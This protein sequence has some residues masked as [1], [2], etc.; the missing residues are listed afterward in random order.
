[1]AYGQAWKHESLLIIS[2]AISVFNLTDS[3]IQWYAYSYQLL[4]FTSDNTDWGQTT[5]LDSLNEHSSLSLTHMYGHAPKTWKTT[6]TVYLISRLTD[7]WY[8]RL[9][10]ATTCADNVALHAFARRRLA[11]Q[12]SIDTSCIT[13]SSWFAA[14]DPRWDRQT[15]GRK[16]YRYIDP[17]PKVCRYNWHSAGYLVCAFPML[18]YRYNFQIKYTESILSNS[19]RKLLW[20]EIT[21]MLIAV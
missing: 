13:C 9:R 20:F 14:V 5:L 18:K 15:D 6:I 19:T 10:S 12:Q 2:L 3:K 16:P 8:T 7:W 21:E 17:A 1:M 11:V 4:V